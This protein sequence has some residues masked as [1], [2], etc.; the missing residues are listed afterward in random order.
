M[1]ST[2]DKTNYV[3]SIVHWV[4]GG[5]VAHTNMDAIEA[6]LAKMVYTFCNQA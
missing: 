5:S 6:N 3:V 1:P 4:F 2:V